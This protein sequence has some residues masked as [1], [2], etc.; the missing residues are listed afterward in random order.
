MIPELYKVSMLC[1]TFIDALVPFLGDTLH[2]L[3]MRKAENL[4]GS[5]SL[6]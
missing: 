3:E 4:T 2:S 6:I 1:I 5:L